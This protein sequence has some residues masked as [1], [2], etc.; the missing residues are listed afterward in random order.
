MSTLRRPQIA[1]DPATHRSPSSDVVV[2]VQGLAKTYGDFRVIAGLDLE[3]HRGEIFG[4]LGPNGAGKT[5]TI[6]LLVGLRRPTSGSVRVLGLDPA[7]DRTEFTARVAVQPQEA[8]IYETLTVAET[9]RLIAALHA[10]PRP[11]AEIAEHIGLADQ[12]RVRVRRLS[13]GQRRRLLLGVALIG[14]PEVVVLDEPSAGLDPAARQSLWALISSLRERGT[15]VVITTHHMDEAAVLCDRVAIVVDG[16]IV[17]LDAPDELVRQSSAQRRVTFTLSGET[18]IDDLRS[19]V[20]VVSL[21]T[22]PLESGQRVDVVTTDSDELLAHL[23]TNG[24][25]PRDLLISTQTLEDVF[26][27]LAETSDYASR[28]RG[29]TTKKGRKQR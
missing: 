26:L 20:G 25:R 8:S 12:A 1:R 3:V 14:D 11:V 6:D 15:T 2:E 28:S 9:L 16:A 4:L 19:H 5:T 13:G 23:I 21:E 27:A 7:V 22:A 10:S 18:A 24:W 29:R 17:A